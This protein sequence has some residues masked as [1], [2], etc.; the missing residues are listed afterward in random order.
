LTN[1]GI[2]VAKVS[3]PCTLSN[4]QAA[5]QILSHIQ[6]MMGWFPILLEE[7][8]ARKVILQLRP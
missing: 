5:A 4:F 1:L 2:L 8:I 6:M 3:V 7:Y